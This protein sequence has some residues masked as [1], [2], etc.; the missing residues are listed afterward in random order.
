M[1]EHSSEQDDIEAVLKLVRREV[2]ERKIPHI[3]LLYAEGITHVLDT[4]CAFGDF[5]DRQ[6]IRPRGREKEAGG[7]RPTPDVEDRFPER[8]ISRAPSSSMKRES[9]PFE[10]CSRMPVTWNEPKTW[11]SDHSNLIERARFISGCA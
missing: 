8:S 11:L 1:V 2:E 7:T 10:R 9:K 4:I 5:L 6:H 3:E